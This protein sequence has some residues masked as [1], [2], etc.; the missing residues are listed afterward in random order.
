MPFYEYRC[1]ACNHN[2]EALQK[3]SDDALVDCPACNQPSL[4]KL[5]SAAGFR[6]KGQG[7]YETDFK[8]GTKRN[9]A[10]SGSS[11]SAS[12]AGHTCG[13]GCSH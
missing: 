9:L 6:L 1:D 8:S 12:S 13:T 4:K 11:E 10:E 5:I 3:I 2:F 7:W